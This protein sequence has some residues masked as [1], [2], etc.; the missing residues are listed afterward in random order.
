M[1]KKLSLLLALLMMMTTVFTSLPVAAEEAKTT[2]HEIVI[3]HTNDVHAR[4]KSDEREKAIGYG[5]IKTYKDELVKEGKTVIAIDAGD[6]LHG[7]TFAT[8]S[9]GDSII[10]LLNEVGYDYMVPGNHDFNYGYQRLVELTG[11]GKFKTLASNVVTEQGKR[12]FLE[13]D[14]KEVDG[15]KIGFFGL[16]TPETYYKSHPSNTKGIVIAEPVEV[17]K[18]QVAALKAKGADFIV[19][20]GHLGL[21]DSTKEVERSEG[22]LKAVPGIDLFIDGHSH[23]ALPE[24]KVIGSTLLAQTGSY[25]NNLGKITLTFDGNKIENKKAELISYEAMSLVKPD[26]KIEAIEKEVD[27]ANK[28]FLEKIVGK[29]LVDL[30]G[31]REYNR[32]EETNL[33]NLV[34]D[35]MREVSKADIA[36]TNGGGIR[37]TIEKGDVT[38][39]EVLTAFPFTNF[40]VTVD[41]TGKEVIQALENGVKAA[42]EL[43]GSFCQVS[44]LTFK[45]DDTAKAGERVFDV[46]VAGKPIDLEKTYKVATNDFIAGGGD[47]YDVFKG[48]TETGQYELLSET[49]A[50]YIAAKKEVNPQVE[51]RITVAKKDSAEEKGFEDIKGMW[52]EEFIKYSVEKGYFSG[53]TKTKFGPN[54][55]VTRAMVVAVLGRYENAEKTEEKVEFTDVTGTEYYA[56]YLKW[57]KDNKIVA[58][59]EDGT[60]KPNK[61]IT[62]A[63]LASIMTRYLRDYKKMEVKGEA[64]TFSDD[65]KLPAWAK[66]DVYDC[67]KLGIIKGFKD[68]HKNDGSMFYDPTGFASRAQLATIFYNLDHAK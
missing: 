46:M 50:K 56:P 55:S 39:G 16:C 38:M 67:V 36:I 43:A 54:N 47:Q 14:I 48:K 57:A 17:A 28:P 29:T 2:K 63:E 25:T 65:A 59:Y 44:G 53:L 51:G 6:V 1:K 13:N 7:T 41:L 24:G 62:R 33:G 4:V 61:E 35:A 31:R 11:Q 5:K 21:D 27:E 20:I 19:A 42:P 23:T 49:L 37:A 10:K 58:G 22:V 3:L 68:T 60:F 45:Y 9:R 26:E 15:V 12:D 40:T 66:T 64:P 52:A 34:T 30:E 18:Q 8:I 32:K